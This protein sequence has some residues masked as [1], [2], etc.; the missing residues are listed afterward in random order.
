MIVQWIGQDEIR[1]NGNEIELI[2]CSKVFERVQ[3][4]WGSMP[5][6]I[7][8]NKLNWYTPEGSDHASLFLREFVSKVQGSWVE[9]NL[10]EEIC[11]CRL[12]N[13]NS[14]DIA[15]QKGAR[16]LDQIR[17]VTGASGGCGTCYLGVEAIL[18]RRIK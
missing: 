13:A 18:N 16:S 4:W 2:V 15:I 10:D 12:V 17:A 8:N 3:K 1:W 14:I 6:E 7:Q 11:H 5:K 9:I